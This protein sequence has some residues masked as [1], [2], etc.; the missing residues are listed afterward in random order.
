MSDP[1][2]SVVIPTYGGMDGL[3]ELLQ[4]LAMSLRGR[5]L[6]EVVV[7][8][9]ASPDDTWQVLSELSREHPELHAIDLLSNQGQPLATMCGLAHAQGELVATMDDDLQHPPEELPKLVAALEMNAHWDVVVG[10][11]PRDEGWFRD[12]GSKINEAVDR[13]AHGTPKGFRHSA[14][15][16]MRR[17]VVEALVANQTRSPVIWS[18]LGQVATQ[19]H[20]VEVQHHAR[21][22]GHSGFRIRDGVKL[23]TTSF[24]QASTLPLRVLSGLGFASAFLAFLVGGIYLLRWMLGSQAPMGWTS[25]FLAVTFFGGMTLFGL[26]L[27]GEY[28]ALMMREVRQPP[29]WWIRAEITQSAPRAHGRAPRP[30]SRSPGR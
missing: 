15:R 26:G 8:N 9:D 16:V 6:Y 4:R 3:P 7:V 19:V 13:L 5:W 12:L 28:L 27:I 11:W 10:S 22:Y 18:L 2:L 21:S 30:P 29:R 25:S 17:P 24:F 20:N 1:Q 23:V 14:F